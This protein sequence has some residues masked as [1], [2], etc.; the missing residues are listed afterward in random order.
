MTQ[1]IDWQSCIALAN[2]NTDL[3]KDLLEMMV[4]ELP[5]NTQDLQTCLA[6]DNYEQMEHL[7]HRLHGAACYCSVPYLKTAARDLETY[8]KNNPTPDKTIIKPL[9]DHLIGA[10]Q[11][12]QHAYQTLDIA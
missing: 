1:V 2:N 10:I 12:V 7:V 5:T 8:L 9:F 11:D 4:A 6:T 3:A